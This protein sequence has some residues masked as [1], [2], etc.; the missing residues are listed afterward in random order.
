MGARALARDCALMMLFGAELNEVD[1][2][3]MVRDFFPGLATAADLM[4]DEESRQ[5]GEQITRGVLDDLD[6]VDEIIRT[7]STFW[8]VERM[9]RTDRNVLRIAVWELQHNVPRAVALNEAV[10]LAK[11]FGSE[12]S[13]AFVNGVL[14]RIANDLGAK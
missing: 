5:Y 7:A 8:R 12:D 9:S 2:G 3:R 11:R 14:T 10:E 1:A 6:A 4:T 13:G